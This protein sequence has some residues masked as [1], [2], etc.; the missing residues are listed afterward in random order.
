MSVPASVAARTRYSSETPGPSFTDLVRSE[1]IKLRTVRTTLWCLLC[2]TAA[3]LGTAGL[4]AAKDAPPNTPGIAWVVSVSHF[5]F[6]PGQ[7]AVIVLAITAVG[8]EYGTGLIHTSLATVPWRERWL[9]AKALVVALLA[10]AAGAVLSVAAFALVYLTTPEV[11]GPVLHPSVLRAVPGP[12]LYL[13]GLAVLSLAVGALVRNTAGGIVVMLAFTFVVPNLVATTASLAPM[14]RFLPAGT[15]PPN[16]GMAITQVGPMLGGLSPWAGF[17][18]LC[19]W[20]G[21]MLA[22]AAYL[23]RVRD[24]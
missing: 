9:A 14:E 8:S 3:V 17:G 19:A 16:A 4:I 11:S 20:A 22:G 18:V 1:W 13:A 6:M 24:A 5:G 15:T 21:A 23:L 2:L 7:I 12:G 10:L